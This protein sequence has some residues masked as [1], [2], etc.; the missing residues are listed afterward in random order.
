MDS[1]LRIGAY[2]TTRV[3]Y[4]VCGLLVGI[5]GANQICLCLLYPEFSPFDIE[6][7][8]IY[9]DYSLDA[10]LTQRLGRLM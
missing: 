1:F 2:E 7:F 4:R 9:I 8:I 10:S 5:R 6:Y 3:C